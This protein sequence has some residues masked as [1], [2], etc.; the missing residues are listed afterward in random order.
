VKRG[1]KWQNYL[2]V[3][4]LMIIRF[5][6]E[7]FSFFYESMAMMMMVVVV[8]MMVVAMMVWVVTVVM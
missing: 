3:N 7:T 8:I 1:K 6:Y 4:L 5:G 2:A